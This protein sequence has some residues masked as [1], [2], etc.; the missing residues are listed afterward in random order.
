ML[1]QSPQQNK[2]GEGF[3]R[4]VIYALRGVLFILIGW[5]MFQMYLSESTFVYASMIATGLVLFSPN[6]INEMRKGNRLFGWNSTLDRAIGIHKKTTFFKDEVLRFIC[7]ENDN[8]IIKRMA[9]NE[10]G[11]V[12]PVFI[13]VGELSKETISKEQYDFLVN[14]K[15]ENELLM[16]A[17]LN[18]YSLF[19]PL[20]IAVIW[21]HNLFH[22]S[23]QIGWQQMIFYV[24]W[25]VYFIY[26]IH[27][28]KG[29]MSTMRCSKVILDY[30]RE[31]GY[32][33]PQ[34][35]KTIDG[36]FIVEYKHRHT[37]NIVETV[38]IIG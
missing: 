25:H 30:Q 5:I 10:K 2:R 29:G 38:L 35:Y 31:N 13:L 21:F 8:H 3:E 28:R 18:L 26:R 33:N 17:H 4:A 9:A 36:N 15:R 27:N 6:R 37:Q 12:K 11:D 14:R 24:L 22:E 23:I 19:V 16:E 1:E 20:S 7:S 32:D 34:I